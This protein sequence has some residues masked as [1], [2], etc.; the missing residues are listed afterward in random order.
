M[1]SLA[2]NL[3]KEWREQRGALGVLAAVAFG[4]VS[5]STVVLSR[6]T[7]QDPL[8]AQ[9]I[10]GLTVLATVMS[11]G[12]DLLARE[13]QRGLAFLARI[14]HGLER[15]A[16]GKLCFFALV[17]FG[18]FA[19]GSL[20]AAGASFVRTGALPIGALDN[21]SLWLP[22]ALAVSL[23]V[24]AVSAWM[25]NSALTLPATALFL[26]V[27]AWPA[28]L[29]VVDD[30]I[31]RPTP[32]EG[33]SF[34]ALCIAGA[35]VSAW[36]SFVAGSR[37]GR[38]RAHATVI[39]M[40]VAI[41]FFAPAWIWA[42]QRHWTVKHAPF[43]I[44]CGLVA[45]GERYAFLTL[46]RRAPPGSG[47]DA[48]RL[49]P[50]QCPSA[51]IV[52]LHDGS[53]RFAGDVDR[54]EFTWD[55]P[56]NRRH[57]ILGDGSCS[58][59]LLVDRDQ[60]SVAVFDGDTA[61]PASNAE[62][63]HELSPKPSDFGLAIEPARYQISWAG[64]GQKLS[65]YDGSRA[66]HAYYRDLAR[67]IVIKRAALLSGEDRD[68]RLDVRIRPGRWLVGER[69]VQERPGQSSL[70]GH[71]TWRWLDPITHT[72]EA[73]T[74]FDA[75]DNINM[76]SIDDGRLVVS[77]DR[78]AFV[79]DPETG[80]RIA[81]QALGDKSVI[82]AVGDFSPGSAPLRHDAPS[83]VLASNRHWWGV[84]SLDTRDGGL[85]L[86]PSSGQGRVYLLCG[87]GQQALAIE[88]AQRVV[89]YDLERGARDVLFDVDAVN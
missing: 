68:Q 87:H 76:L 79:L 14:P 21:A 6:A 15:A 50:Y 48:S 85:R 25:P 35:P 39:G 2:V 41:P 86:A 80:E 60:K 22:I 44:Q 23:W 47:F 8:V 10:V 83:I 32:I 18:A 63:A 66:Q 42:G 26:G 1:N 4:A 89:H 77:N 54:N 46:T 74:C 81:V 69:P 52:D 33:I 24:F 40:L 56:Y 5:I 43:E 67:N 36:A 62:P 58:R 78:G 37:R 38:S 28:V 73:A 30:A 7:L 65:V 84:A 31:F 64:V 70:L 45:A 71:A 3:S 59:I 20:L 53:W 9:W 17:L 29:A 19:Y 16:R 72:W 57:G 82:W 27:F 12:A 34:V 61:Q 51:L 75:R 13:R 88:D 55:W 49:D 11:I